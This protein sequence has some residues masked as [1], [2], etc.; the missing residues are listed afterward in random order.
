MAD[1]TVRRVAVVG[2][3]R[4]PFCR[5]NTL[6]GELTNLDMMSTALQGLVEHYDLEGA[7][8]DEVV[9][10]AVI[11]HAQGLEPHARGRCFQPTCIPTRPASP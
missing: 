8:I 6:Y 9:G 3:I 4:T 2:G 10:G 1:Q 7:L 11:T 5:S